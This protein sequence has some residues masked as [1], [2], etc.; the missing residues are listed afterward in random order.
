MTFNQQADA[1]RF[2]VGKVVAQAALEGATLSKAEQHMRSWSESNPDFTPDH[3]LAERRY[4][5]NTT[6]VIRVSRIEERARS[7]RRR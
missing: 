3:P 7:G 6:G 1:K 2:F 5:R 4:V